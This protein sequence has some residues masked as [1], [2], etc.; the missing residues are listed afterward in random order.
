ML[1]IFLTEAPFLT[2]LSFLLSP[3]GKFKA[4]VAVHGLPG[5]KRW[6]AYHV[7]KE[8]MGK[9]RRNSI[10]RLIVN[11]FLLSRGR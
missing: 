4:G 2:L 1:A 8:V 10:Q 7:L 6:G 5:S 11:N 9:G 3:T